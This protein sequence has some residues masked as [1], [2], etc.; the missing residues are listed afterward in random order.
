MARTKSASP[1]QSQVVVRLELTRSAKDALE[2]VSGRAGM[3]Q[4]AVQARLLEWFTTQSDLVQGAVLGHYP[5]EIQAEVAELILRN[6]GK[7]K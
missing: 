3:T 5:A 2:K 4:S 6:I 1:Q 7:R